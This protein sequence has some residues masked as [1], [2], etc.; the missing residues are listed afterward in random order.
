[1]GEYSQI[2]QKLKNFEFYAPKFLK[3]RDKKGLTVPL[4]LNS[5]QRIVYERIKVLKALGKAIKLIILKARQQGISTLAEGLIFHDT[6]SRKGRKSKI[7]A[8]DPES[9]TAI[10]EMTKFY[11]DNL[12]ENI[13]PIKR[14][15]STK[16]LVFENPDDK[17]RRGSAGLRS[18]IQ[19]A[20]ANKKEVRGSTI[21]NFHAS[22]IAFW[23]DA[24]KLM[25][26]ALQEIPDHSDTMIIL[27]ST[28]NGVGGYFYDTYWA[29]KRKE[30]DFE[31][32][33]LPW[34][35]F[36]YYSR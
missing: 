7:V 25:L 30:N 6:A 3:I 14:Y 12:P 36:P 18:S 35:I 28:G 29:A 34:H 21:Q 8:H 5:A 1:M 23:P 20:T 19:V 4:V 24:E 2:N 32:I 10:F 13:A 33:F 17:M 9:T 16:R 26:A 27:E 11:Y 15:D 31:A 22:E